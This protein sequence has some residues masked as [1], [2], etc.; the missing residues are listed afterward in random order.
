MLLKNFDGVPLGFT[1]YD[2]AKDPFLTTR[3]LQLSFKL[4]LITLGFKLS[5]LSSF[6]LHSSMGIL[7]WHSESDL[8][9]VPTA[10][11]N[12][13]LITSFTPR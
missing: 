4:S 7:V 11:I 6:A 13:H 2:E 3:S 8:I 1:S 9:P 5:P 12:C 10:H